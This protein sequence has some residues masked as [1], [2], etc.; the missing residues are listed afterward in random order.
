MCLIY[1]YEALNLDSAYQPNWLACRPVPVSV[2]FSLHLPFFHSLTL[3]NCYFSIICCFWLGCHF[4]PFRFLWFFTF[5]W[6]NG[7]FRSAKKSYSQNTF[8]LC[9]TKQQFYQVFVDFVWPNWWAAT[10]GFVGSILILGFDFVAG[11]F[12]NRAFIARFCTLHIG[13]RPFVEQ[14]P[15][16]KLNHC[17]HTSAKMMWIELTKSEENPKAI[18]LMRSIQKV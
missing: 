1:R 2:S 13:L 4:F 10:G 17:T 6:H 14:I 3:T 12:P 16:N 5:C 7:N 11:E 15:K 9:H 8:H 18:K